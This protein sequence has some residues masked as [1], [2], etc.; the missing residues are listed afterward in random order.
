MIV[1]NLRPTQNF[2]KLLGKFTFFQALPVK[3]RGITNLTHKLIQMNLVNHI[4]NFPS[5]FCVSSECAIICI[6]QISAKFMLN[7]TC[8]ASQTNC[9]QFKCKF[10]IVAGSC[11][12]CN[13]Q[14]AYCVCDI[15]I[16]YISLR[17]FPA[18]A[19]IIL[20][21]VLDCVMHL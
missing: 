1:F 17:T 15:T 10:E 18:L 9:H 21:F 3:I 14:Y 4:A 7:S 5:I 16:I 19:A 8:S 11:I 20:V 13:H 6:R 12:V 2:D